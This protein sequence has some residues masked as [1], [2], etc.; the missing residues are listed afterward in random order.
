MHYTQL[1]HKRMIEREGDWP[2]WPVLPLKNTKRREPDVPSMPLLGVIVAGKPT[3]VLITN[4]FD[5][6]GDVP[7]QEYPS[8]DAMLADGWIVD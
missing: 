6:H 8:I 5:M 2:N 3:R 7:V 1:D 4:M